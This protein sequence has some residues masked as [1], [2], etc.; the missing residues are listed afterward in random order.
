M[1]LE[2]RIETTTFKESFVFLKLLGLDTAAEAVP[3]WFGLAKPAA[4]STNEFLLKQ[5]VRWL[6]K[7][8]MTDDAMRHIQLFQIC[9]IFLSQFNGQSADGIFKMRDF[10]CPDDR[11]RHW[12]LL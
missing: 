11:R 1:L 9:D 3:L 5:T 2:G 10:R 8:R 4:Y 12:L 7:L 6:E